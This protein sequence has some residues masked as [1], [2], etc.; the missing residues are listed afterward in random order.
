[1]RHG[2]TLFNREKK[3]QGWCDS[4]LLPS[5]IAQAQSARR[6]FERR[7]ITFDYACCSTSERT[8]DTLEH[9]VSLPYDRYKG[10][11]EWNFGIFEGHD[12]TL[13]P[14]LPYQDYFRTYGGETEAE[15]AERMTDTLTRIMEAPEHHTVLAVSHSGACA[16]FFRKWKAYSEVSLEKHIGNCSI[17]HYAYE[18]HVFRCLEI[19]RPET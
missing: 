13:L 9:I 12:Q 19:I 6:E 16:V 14:P 1:M 11:K 17:F 4:P 8:S 15:I 5:G 7:N 2:E 3:I 10:L 18:D